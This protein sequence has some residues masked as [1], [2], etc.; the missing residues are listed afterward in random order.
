MKLFAVSLF[1]LAAVLFLGAC[2][3]HPFE[4]TKVL[5][6]KF[7]DHGHHAEGGEHKTEGGH[8]A[9]GSHGEAAKEGHKAEAKH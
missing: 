6:A 5:H 3:S 7:Q 8:K 4:E 2:D 1:S 9:E